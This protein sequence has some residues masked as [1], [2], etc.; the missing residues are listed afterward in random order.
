MQKLMEAVRAGLNHNSVEIPQTDYSRTYFDKEE[1]ATVFLSFS[2][3]GARARVLQGR[4]GSLEA[5]VQD[6]V[7]KGEGVTADAVKLDILTGIQPVNKD[8]SWININRHALTY[9]RREDGLMFGDRISPLMFLPEEVEAYG[10]IRG[11]K[12]QQ[13]HIFRAFDKHQLLTEDRLSKEIITEEWHDVYKFRTH[14]FYIDDDGY[15]ELFRGHRVFNELQAGDL[16][17]AVKLSRD[18]YF[19]QAVNAQGKFVYSF[20]PQDNQVPKGYN[21]LR[22]AGT[23]YSMLEIQEF[24]PE[25][26]LQRTIEKT[27]RYL[28]KKVKRIEV[29]GTDA[30]V[31]VEN[32]N[33]KLGGNGLGIIALAQYTKVTG[34]RQYI[35]LMRDMAKWM[36]TIQDETG[37]F[38]V[39][40]QIYSSKEHTDFVSHYY[41]GEAI[42]S[43]VRLYQVDP[44]EA[45]L[46]AAEG[47]AN[48]LIH[49]RDSKET[50]KTITHDH[51]LL[52]ALNELHQ[53]RPKEDYAA[54]SYFIAEAI[55][56]TQRL[57]QHEVDREWVGSYEMKGIPRSTPTACRTEG[58]GAVYRLA[59]R[60]EKKDM[61]ERCRHAMAEAV[62]FQLQMQFQPESVLY[63]DHKKLCLGALHESLTSYE[64]RNDY[65][66]HNI[67]SFLSLYK[68]LLEK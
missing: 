6:A 53:E 11:G 55:M 18:N 66:Q 24:F 54:H 65:T 57:D 51:W 36:L 40:K 41:S 9:K 45:W 10:M 29:N 44:D 43:L 61:A 56:D 48:Y 21:I 8:T 34:D 64:I 67:S 3:N 12:L 5:A 16:K 37:K 50:K 62:K 47:E 2:E 19:T 63:L 25:E 17:E 59:Q 68:I 30:Q 4:G 20:Q 38:S 52:Y 28:L 58:L 60:Q 23:A 49:R 31:I 7:K 27:I 33:I 46:D 13:E 15:R 32:D 1:Q 42:L 22:H 35:P 26:Q 14:S 39:H